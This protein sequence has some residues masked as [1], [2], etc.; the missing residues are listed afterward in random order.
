MS[1]CETEEIV[2]RI[3]EQKDDDS[4]LQELA[5]QICSIIFDVRS[6]SIFSTNTNDHPKVVP[7]EK[8]EKVKSLMQQFRAKL[9]PLFEEKVQLTDDDL[10]SQII[11]PLITRLID[12]S[13]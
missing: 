7:D 9:G 13:A 6:Q 11:M 10:Y 1:N 5:Q 2:D 12:Q 4:G 8:K 3:L